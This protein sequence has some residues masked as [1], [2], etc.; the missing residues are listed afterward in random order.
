MKY[1]FNLLTES[2]AKFTDS[3]FIWY[4]KEFHYKE[5]QYSEDPE[6]WKGKNL[7]GN[8]RF[9]SVA[10]FFDKDFVFILPLS[11]I[12]LPETNAKN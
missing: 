6:I 7:A 10:F 2:H 8:M 9:F 12:K 11:A 5:L 4:L 3:K 1:I